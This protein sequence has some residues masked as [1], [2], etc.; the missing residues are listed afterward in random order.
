M[1][2]SKRVCGP[3]ANTLFHHRPTQHPR[4]PPRLRRRTKP[5]RDSTTHRCAR[6]VRTSERKFQNAPAGAKRPSWPPSSIA[7]RRSCF[8]HRPPGMSRL[9]HRAAES[10]VTARYRPPGMGHPMNA[11]RYALYE[12][13]RAPAPASK[14]D[15]CRPGTDALSTDD[16]VLREAANSNR[17][18]S[19]PGP[20]QKSSPARF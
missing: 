8:H 11:Q 20:P 16:L 19:A 3:L 13:A 15:R 18:S 2:C 14:S 10:C 1:C 6:R 12:A 17:W 9:Q 7:R 4:R 5:T